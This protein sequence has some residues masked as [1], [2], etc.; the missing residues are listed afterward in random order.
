M[1][2]SG[3]LPLAG[4]GASTKS[5]A[6]FS[7]KGYGVLVSGLF[8][9]ETTDDPARDEFETMLGL[10]QALAQ[11]I[12]KDPL[13]DL[14]FAVDYSAGL[15]SLSDPV[16]WPAGSVVKTILAPGT[17]DPT[18]LHALYASPPESTQGIAHKLVHAHAS[19]AGHYEVLFDVPSPAIAHPNVVVKITRIQSVDGVDPGPDQDDLEASVQIRS[20]DSASDQAYASKKLTPNHDVHT[21]PWIVQRKMVDDH[22][23]VSLWLSDF[24][25][26]PASGYV[27]GAFGT[28]SDCGTV[29]GHSY[30]PCPDIVT[31]IDLDP[32]T[33]GQWGGELADPGAELDLDLKTG[34][35]TGDATGQVGRKLVV[36]GNEK[37]RGKVEL[38]ITVQ[39]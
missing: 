16:R 3:V 11:Q 34:K 12:G 10:A 27:S 33:G 18:S 20:T 24:T 9:V 26:G 17:D 6:I 31:P 35:I 23:R 21:T 14:A 32:Q 38:V 2:S 22:V 37:A 36:Q 39:P 19:G 25:A 5:S 30:P 28:G 8:E 7:G 15:L 1:P 29:N 4:G 13:A